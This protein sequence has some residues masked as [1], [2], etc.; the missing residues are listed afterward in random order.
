MRCEC[1]PCLLR[2]TIYECELVSEKLTEQAVR[3]ALKIL[4]QEYFSRANSV[5]VATKIHRKVY[6]ILGN[7]D[8]YK[9]LKER[10]NKVAL[11]LQAQVEAKIKSSNNKLESAMLC[12][13]IGNILDFGIAHD[14]GTPEKLVDEFEYFWNLGFGVND[15]A[16]AKKYL[17]KGNSIVFLPDNCGEIIFDKLLCEQLKNFNVHL[18]II[19]KEK[20]MLTDATL[21]EVEELKFKEIVDEILTSTNAVG[22]DFN[23]ISNEVKT[24]IENADLII[25]KGMGLYEAF[26]ETNYKPILYLLR[27][28]C[29]PVA[30]DMGLEKNIN[31]AKLYE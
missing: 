26:C 9:E 29:A 16:K 14:Y 22:I 21:K 30:E 18:T 15:S 20:P 3:E 4:A 12:S 13:I 19:V 25:C 8:P 1:V 10:S 17:R 7:E 27:T 31:V 24:V 11:K 2:R 23:E 6:Q 5:K 28:K